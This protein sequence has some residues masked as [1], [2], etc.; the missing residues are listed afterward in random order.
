M[1]NLDAHARTDAVYSDQFA[2]SAVDPSLPQ[3]FVEFHKQNFCKYFGLAPAEWYG[4]SV[5][6]TGAGPGKHAA[7]LCLL[8]AHVTA[9]DLLES[10]VRAIER[11]KAAHQFAHLVAYRANLMQPLPSEWTAFDLIS[12]H[13][14][15]QHAEDPGRVLELLAER[16]RVG[17][18]L[19]LSVYESGT[20]RF[21][22]SQMAREVLQWQDRDIVKA[23]IPSFFPLGFLEFEN[24]RD[25]YFENILD[26]F[27]VPY[28][29]RFRYA[30]LVRFLDALG[31]EVLT[32]HVGHDWLSELDNE[33]LKVG[34][35][36]TSSGEKAR[37]PLEY[38]IDEFDVHQIPE[39]PIRVV[40]AES[41]EWARRAI[42]T[43]RALPADDHYRR[44]A[45][46]LGL[47]RLRGTFSRARG[48]EARHQALQ[49][50][51]KRSVT[52]DVSSIRAR[53]FSRQYFARQAT[54]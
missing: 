47:Y 12:V 7:V 52:G 27:F 16:L 13:N 24:A 29:W 36:K 50:Y 17:G 39:E 44:A 20:F 49:D 48:L 38:Q 11:L 26:D 8:G 45:F 21:F 23:F 25:I 31:F 53:T 3:G 9:V 18:R 34:F 42:A 37:V 40:L 4:K 14:W 6:E 51:L 32:P 10:N 30:S 46:C 35:I 41:A 22:I 33:Y 19:Y 5:L 1:K 15:L 2:E 28:L 43:L 54:P